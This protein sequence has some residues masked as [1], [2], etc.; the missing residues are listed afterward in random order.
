VGC[1]PALGRRDRSQQQQCAESELDLYNADSE[2]CWAPIDQRISAMPNEE[3]ESVYAAELST[4]ECLAEHGF[5]VEA[6]PSQQRFIDT[7]HVERWSAYT[8]S[9]VWSVE[10]DDGQWRA[11]NEACPQPSWSLGV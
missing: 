9:D 3:I 6:P 1:H 4:S 7:F 11:I 2:E 8:A 5:T 10:S